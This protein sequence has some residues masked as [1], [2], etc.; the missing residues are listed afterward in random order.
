MDDLKECPF[1]GGKDIRFMGYSGMYQNSHC[2]CKDCH[3][4]GPAVFV[5]DG[6]AAT[7]AWNRR[8]VPQANAE[9]DAQDKIDAARYRSWRL[10]VITG[11]EEMVDR[12]ADALPNS[13]D[14]YP[15]AEQWDA[16]V[17][18]AIRAASNAASEVKNG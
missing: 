18:A 17:D 13:E 7:E 1:C 11:D 8:A 4:I 6:K 16:A 14:E 15:T 10:A 9:Q 5:D 12:V 3:T 2:E